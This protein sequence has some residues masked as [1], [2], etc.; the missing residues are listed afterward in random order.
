MQVEAGLRRG[1]VLAR[2][3]DCGVICSCQIRWYRSINCE[4]CQLDP[5]CWQRC[6]LSINSHGSR[7]KGIVAGRFGATLWTF[8]M[9]FVR[10]VRRLCGGD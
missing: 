10:V 3:A 4:P 6:R 2:R 7:I 5:I 9:R 8:G 1:V